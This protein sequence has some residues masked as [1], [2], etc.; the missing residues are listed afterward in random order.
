MVKLESHNE[1]SVAAL[2]R[3]GYDGKY[4]GAIGSRW[5]VFK[6]AAGNLLWCMAFET[7]EE[8][9]V[10]TPVKH[11]AL[12][13]LAEKVR[14]VN[15][16]SEQLNSCPPASQS[17]VVNGLQPDLTL[18]EDRNLS[19]STQEHIHGQTQDHQRKCVVDAQHCHYKKHT[20]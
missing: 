14:Q 18:S 20:A 5:Y 3:H 4:Y 9:I 12:P 16:N 17:P 6:M 13:S 8:A 11:N 2:L 15:R 19:P 1:T 10:F 7:E